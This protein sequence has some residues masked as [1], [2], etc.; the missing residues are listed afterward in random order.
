MICFNVI[1]KVRIARAVVKWKEKNW[2]VKRMVEF[3]ILK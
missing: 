3:K 2:D 1:K